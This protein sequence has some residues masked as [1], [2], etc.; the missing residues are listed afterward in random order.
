MAL[1]SVPK[2]QLRAILPSG[3]D[4]TKNHETRPTT[5]DVYEFIHSLPPVDDVKVTEHLMLKSQAVSPI[6]L[7]VRVGRALFTWEH[8]K[9]DPC[10]LRYET[11]ESFVFTVSY[12]K[13]TP[14]GNNAK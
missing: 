8:T 10:F 9:N 3:L 1:Q 14:K 4:F 11:Y 2:Y 5:R 13:S 12:I 7:E 6:M